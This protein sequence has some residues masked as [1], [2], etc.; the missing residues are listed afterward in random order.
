MA[1]FDYRAYDADGV[2]HAGSLDVVSREAALSALALR[3]QHALEVEEAKDKV[4]VRWWQREVFAAQGLREADRLAFTREL[5]ALL[6]ADLPVDEALGVVLLQPGLSARVK[7]VTGRIHEEVR[8][9]QSLSRALAAEGSSFPE[10]YW[11][12]VSAGETGGALGDVMGDLSGYLDRAAEVRGRISAALAYPMLLLAAAI[13]AVLVI[14]L[15]LIPA[16]M[17]L[18]ADAGVAPPLVLEAL[19]GIEK[20]ARAHWL[21]ILIAGG[22]ATVALAVLGQDRGMRQLRDRFLLKLPVVKGMIAT[23]ET[24]RLS[25]ILATQMKN[26]V[27]L[28]DALGGIAGV[29]GNRVYR[30]AVGEVAAGIAEGAPLSRELARTGL[31]S[32]LAIRLT[33]VG[34]KT[35]QLEIMLTRAAD[36]H[37]A[38]LQRSIDRLTRMLGPLLT[39]AVGLLAGGLILS[40]MQAIL[41]INDLALR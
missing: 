34:E 28:L 37:E 36:I 4:E 25:R 1:R 41:S 17:P 10:Y 26:G 32:E 38:A 31:F 18:F 20:F 2:L 6:K 40:V 33:G 21:A 19:A 35:G 23:R 3:G 29:M 15:V 5:A 9:G 8:G 13:A 7:A 14:M 39:L 27:P 11:R 24:A 30:Q 22:V 16:V 12:L